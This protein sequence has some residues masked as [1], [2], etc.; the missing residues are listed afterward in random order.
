LHASYWEK[1]LI[2]RSYCISNTFYFTFHLRH[3]C[4]FYHTPVITT[5]QFLFVLLH[6]AFL[7]FCPFLFAGLKFVHLK[8]DCYTIF[9]AWWLFELTYLPGKT[10]YVYKSL[11]G[12][13]SHSFFQE[14]PSSE[15][16]VAGHLESM[17]FWTF[18]WNIHW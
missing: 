9:I 10:W 17:V 7:L 15:N 8:H 6:I 13:N 11:E 16:E 18:A 1:S 2:L 12:K 5:S 4:F 3:K 14:N